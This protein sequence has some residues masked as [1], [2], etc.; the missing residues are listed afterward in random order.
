MLLK[1][2][3]MEHHDYEALPVGLWRHLYSWY[4]A[5]WSIVRFLRRDTTQGVFLDL[6]P[7]EGIDPRYDTSSQGDGRNDEDGEGA[8]A[9]VE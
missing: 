5:D 7:E 8:S 3:L 9:T 2:N 6:Y 4:S 1:P